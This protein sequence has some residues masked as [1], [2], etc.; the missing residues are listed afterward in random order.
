MKR[1]KHGF[2]NNRIYNIYRGMK[3]R[4][5]NNK[6]YHY[7]W[8]GAKG[9]KICDE[10][11]NDFMSFYNWAINNGYK[12]DL[13]IDRINTHGNYE[14][15]NCRWVTTK[16]QSNNRKNNNL[17][18]INGVT[19]TLSEW[20]EISGVH[21][22]AIYRKLKKGITGK[23]L[24]K[25]VTTPKKCKIIQKDL[26]HNII[27]TWDCLEKIA[28]ETGYKKTPIANVCKKKEHCRTAYGFLWEY[29]E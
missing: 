6:D 11:L 2:T 19:H 8:Y 29:L 21:H 25:P 3:T 20:S 16:Q 18:T 15:S 1:Q 9:I 13:T 17:I 10:W 7:Q 24:L 27:K 28:Q 4:C 14:P 12:D 5:Y 22:K 26:N 23:D